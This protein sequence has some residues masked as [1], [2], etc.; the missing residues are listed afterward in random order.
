M[1]S[2]FIMN[3]RFRDHFKKNGV[4]CADAGK[5]KRAQQKLED[6]RVSR[7]EHFSRQ[8][9]LIGLSDDSETRSK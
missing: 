3:S 5:Y 6:R 1:P 8:R 4:L 2:D 7:T 9:N